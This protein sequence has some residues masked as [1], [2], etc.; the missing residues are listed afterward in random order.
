MIRRLALVSTWAVLVASSV[1]AATATGPWWPRRP[2]LRIGGADPVAPRRPRLPGLGN[3]GYT[4]L[5]TT[6]TWCTTRRPTGSCP[7]TTWS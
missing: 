5:H 6:S 4:S 2:A 1:G 3:G 7:A